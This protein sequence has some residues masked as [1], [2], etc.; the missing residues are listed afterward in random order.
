[1]KP[2]GPDNPVTISLIKSLKKEAIEKKVKIWKA[3]ASELEKPRRRQRVVNINE[4]NKHCKDNETIIVP[5]KVLALGELD[6][7]ITVA[8]FS[9]SQ[10]ALTKINQKGKAISIPE[11]MK[12][13]PKGSKVRIIG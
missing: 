5:G 10:E 11:L 6:K 13:N 1:M 12:I 3:I 2:T 4:I 7:K 9:F 8:A